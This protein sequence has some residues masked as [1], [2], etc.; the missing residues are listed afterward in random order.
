M[1]TNPNVVTASPNIEQGVALFRKRIAPAVL[2]EDQTTINALGAW[3]LQRGHDVRTM[4]PQAI[5]DA[6]YA[7][8][9]A[10]LFEKNPDGTSILRWVAK[11][12]KL[13]LREQEGRAQIK[14][15]TAAAK[16]FS[17]KVKK[18]EEAAAYEKTQQT[19]QRTLNEL[20]A[21]FSLVDGSGRIAHGKTAAVKDIASKHVDKAI[22]SKRD[23]TVVLKEVQ[24]YLNDE[25]TTAEKAVQYL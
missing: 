5:S 8:C 13:I 20:L 24:K 2:G 10:L 23:L 12:K 17:D 6:L 16:D 1:G 7:A 15:P 3:M 21:N 9:D 22:A 4:T 14:N 18:Q 25:Y 19:A 11:P